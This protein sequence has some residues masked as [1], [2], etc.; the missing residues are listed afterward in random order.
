MAKV[1]DQERKILKRAR[2]RS[3][4]D[5]VTKQLARYAAKHP[6][7]A[8]KARKLAHFVN[9]GARSQQDLERLA[10]EWFAGPNKI[11]DWDDLQDII[12]KI[13]P[14]VASPMLAALDNFKDLLLRYYYET[15]GEDLLEYIKDVERT[16]KKLLTDEADKAK[17]IFQKVKNV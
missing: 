7:H 11:E 5:K 1:A 16:K 4:G 10:R 13:N 8:K 2:N 3:S 12:M 6:Q 9:F 17:L 15:G 14:R